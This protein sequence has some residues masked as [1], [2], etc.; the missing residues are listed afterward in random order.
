MRYVAPAPLA[1]PVLARIHDAAQEQEY[2][3]L[4]RKRDPDSPMLALFEAGYTVEP[5]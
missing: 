1:D 2:L 4:W 5:L 3:R